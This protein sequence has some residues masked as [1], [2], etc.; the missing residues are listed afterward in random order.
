MVRGMTTMEA[1]AALA[2]VVTLTGP[3]VN[4]PKSDCRVSDVLW[5]NRMSNNWRRKR[6]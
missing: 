3:I 6:L 2:M 1:A 5:K 4:E